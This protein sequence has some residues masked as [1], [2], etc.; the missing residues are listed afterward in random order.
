[1]LLPLTAG[2]DPVTTGEAVA[3]LK[4]AGVVLDESRG[5]A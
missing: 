4:A 3:A 1:V 2:V 5:T